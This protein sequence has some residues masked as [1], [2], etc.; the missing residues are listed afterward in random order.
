M[1]CSYDENFIFRIMIFQVILQMIFNDD[2]PDNDNQNIMIVL[3]NLSPRNKRKNWKQNM[4]QKLFTDRGF[5]W[6]WRPE[7]FADQSTTNDLK[8]AGHKSTTIYFFI[9]EIIFRKK[10]VSLSNNDRFDNY[11]IF[12]PNVWHF[13]V[14]TRINYVSIFFVFIVKIHERNSL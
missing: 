12:L 14:I 13:S 9:S 1:K 11:K 7:I 8:V 6:G 4:K 3:K 2:I 10:I 5:S